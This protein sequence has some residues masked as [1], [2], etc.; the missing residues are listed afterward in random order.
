MRPQVTLSSLVGRRVRIW[1]GFSARGEPRNGEKQ[2]FMVGV[3]QRHDL[4]RFV[5]PAPDGR[6]PFVLNETRV[7]D[8]ESDGGWLPVFNGRTV[9]VDKGVEKPPKRRLYCSN[10]GKP[11]HNR[12]GCEE[13]RK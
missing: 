11:G 9:R 4:Y 1:L 6:V 13:K 5:V 3:V 10:C 7:L 2:H 12:A 8:V